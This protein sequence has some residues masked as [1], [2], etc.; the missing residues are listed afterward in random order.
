MAPHR[1]TQDGRVHFAQKRD[2]TWDLAW[3]AAWICAPLTA[4]LATAIVAPLAWPVI[5]ALL[6][7]PVPA[8]LSVAPSWRRL[9]IRGADA[10]VW[11]VASG[12][13]AIL[14][15]GL[16][17][18]FAAL[19]LAPL[20]AAVAPPVADARRMAQGA[21]GALAAVIGVMLF[22]LAGVLA[23][24]PGPAVSAWLGFLAVAGVAL[25]LGAGLI[26][27]QKAVGAQHR[28]DARRAAYVQSV[29]EGQP[30]LVMAV[31]MDGRARALFG[32]LPEGVLEVTLRLRGLEDVARPADRQAVRQA[33]SAAASSGEGFAVFAPETAPDRTLALALRRKDPSLIVGVLRDATA[34]RAREAALEDAREDAESRAAGRARFLANMSHELRTPLN[35]IMGFSDIIQ[36]RLF[37]PISDRYGEYATLIHESGGHLLDLIND[38]LDMS[39][40]EAERYELSRE[41][42]DARDAVTAALRLMRVQADG[43]EIKL[44]GV[45]PP[46]PLEI[47]ADRRALKQIV[48]N[49]VSNALKFTPR[50]GSVSVAVHGV[51]SMFELVVSDTGA[52]I[53]PEDLA[54]LGKPYEQAGDAAGRAL[55]TGLG[56]S[57]VRGLA[58]LHGGEMILESRLG[59]GTSVTVRLPVLLRPVEQ[60]PM[61]S[62]DDPLPQ[63]DNIIAFT[64]PKATNG[65]P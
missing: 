24:A 23:P 27:N 58:E 9:G 45:L 12:A 11:S 4:A 37:G 20:A 39:K 49:L 7:L 62:P 59:A 16:A 51:G 48:L 2:R 34:E 13:A 21:V 10:A 25:T 17:G 61:P 60:P 3:R 26:R 31:S 18:P 64:P 56:L 33:I 22:Q 63:G 50:G 1:D 19:C 32:Q 8:M 65:E 46:R 36:Q 30:N 14:T 5:A 35:A 15:G 55:G 57:L 29:M 42:F 38:L 43:A 6:I 47:D 52:G 41:I 44:R 28:Q 40:I 54:R 53:A